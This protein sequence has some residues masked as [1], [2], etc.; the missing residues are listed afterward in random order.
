MSARSRVRLALGAI[1]LSLVPVGV[2]LASDISAALYLGHVQVTNTASAATDVY[3][4]F[5]LKT[6]NLIDRLMLNET[7]TDAVMRNGAAVDV[8]FMPGVGDN[9]WVLHVPAISD[10]EQDT[11]YLYTAGTTGSKLR[12]FPDAGGMTMDDTTLE[13]GDNFTI[14]Q[15]GYIDTSPGSNKRLVYKGGAFELV[16]SD[17]EKLSAA[18]IGAPYYEYLYPDGAGEFTNIPNVTGAATHWEAVDD[19]QGVPDDDTTKVSTSGAT[20]TYKDQ[21]TLSNTSLDPAT[22]VIREVRVFSRTKGGGSGF[23][24]TATEALTLDGATVDSG[25]HSTD[26]WTDWNGVFAR[27]G[28][29]TWQV[30][31]LDDLK[32]EI[33]LEYG[34]G[35]GAACTQIHVRVEYYPVSAT[36]VTSG[37]HSIS[38]TAD[39]TDLRLYI[40]DVEED[41]TALGGATVPDNVNGWVFLQNGVM[42]YMEYHKV[43]VGGVLKQHIEWEYDTTFTDLSENGNDTTPTFR[44]TP[45]NT[46][47]SAT[48]LSFLPVES[49]DPPAL[50]GTESWELI[51][52]LPE[53]PANLYEELD[54]TFF[55]TGVIQDLA[56]AADWP[57][58]IPVFFYAFGSALIAGLAA[59]RLSMGRHGKGSL[60]VQAVVSLVV[61]VYFTITGGG[62]IPGWVLLPF[63][64]EALAVMMFRQSYNW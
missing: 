50:P 23:S 61:M 3:V 39:S 45:S 16:V 6:Q 48:L 36:G 2:A 52:S 51:E 34:G 32:L 29:G 41:S 64:I 62:V 59:Y 56:T 25:G 53:A 63:G 15:R 14:E 4:P 9:P 26:A 1:T 7:A 21:Y 31:D 35:Y 38:V 8:A 30:S 20:A 17:T 46:D 49:Y 55:G 12:Y 42:P 47:V 54:M 18:V 10:Y 13:L 27:P 33:W 22:D 19:P 44:T 58:A 5:D 40:D 11:F 37:E 57:I 28:G 43:T 24:H 60:L